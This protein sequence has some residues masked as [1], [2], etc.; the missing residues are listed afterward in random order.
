MPDVMQMDRNAPQWKRIRD[1]IAMFRGI[2]L[3]CVEIRL[4][5]YVLLEEHERQEYIDNLEASFFIELSNPTSTA[6]D[7][8]EGRAMLASGPELAKLLIERSGN[9]AGIRE[10]L[11]K[12]M[13]ELHE[14]FDVEG[15]KKF[16]EG[17]KVE[18]QAQAIQALVHYRHMIAHRKAY[19]T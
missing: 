3:S 16:L 5:L 17:K 9:P 8:L 6:L 7:S 2:T 14:N 19:L 10:F 12:Q 1:S 13:K 4:D 18:L 11:W 15:Y